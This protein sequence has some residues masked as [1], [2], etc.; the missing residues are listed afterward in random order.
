MN[1]ALVVQVKNTSNAMANSASKHIVIAIINNQEKQ[2]LIAK[3]KT[4]VD[5]PHLW[6][7]PGGQVEKGETAFVAMAREI[8]E[9]VDLTVQSAAHILQFTHAYAEKVLE[10]DVFRV[11]A[12]T[13]EA[14]GAEGQEIRWVEY[15]ELDNY[16]FPPANSKFKHLLKL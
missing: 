8:K 13:G 1:R 12:F 16:A 2:L 3:R 14:I 6:E 11:E 5:Q 7:L 9:E 15:S 10:F 4:H